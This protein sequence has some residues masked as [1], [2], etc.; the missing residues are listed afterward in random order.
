[1]VQ[2]G[3]VNVPDTIACVIRDEADKIN[4]PQYIALGIAMA[5]SAFDPNAVGDN[6]CSI[7]LFQ[8]NTCGGQGS[9][10]ANNKDALKDPRLNAKIAL[11]P[12][13]GAVYNCTL[14]GNHGEDLIRCVAVNSGH[15]G[16]VD[17]HDPRV[18]NIF[19]DCMLLI[20]NA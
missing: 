11:L 14:N 6:G 3:R 19:N 7:G 16:H 13:A 2:L 1:M 17:L 8:L 10:Y 5:E 12:I 18:T 9:D 20:F 15:P 4:C